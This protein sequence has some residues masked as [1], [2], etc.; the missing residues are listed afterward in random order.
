[1]RIAICKDNMVI[2]NRAVPFKNHSRTNY[3]LRAA[4]VLMVENRLLQKVI[5]FVWER[6][7]V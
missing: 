1:M 7:C 5:A 2:L 4:K 3:S 6:L